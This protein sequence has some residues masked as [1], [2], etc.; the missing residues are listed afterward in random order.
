MPPLAQLDHVVINV[1]F[2]MDLADPLF[3]A[4]GFTLTPRAYDSQGSIHHLMVFGNNYLELSGLTGEAVNTRPELLNSP[5][6]IN[7]L[8]LK[9]S[10]VDQTYAHLQALGMAGDPPRTFSRTVYLSSGPATITLRLVTVRSDVFPAGQVYFCE[11]VT[12]ELVWRS[13][14]QTHANGAVRIAEIVIVSTDCEA[15][16]TRYAN[17]VAAPKLDGPDGIYHISLGEIELS[18]LS[19]THYAARYRDLVSPTNRRP[20][21][22]GAVVMASPD[23]MAITKQLRNMP[24]PAP[25]AISGNRISVRI[26]EFDSVLEFV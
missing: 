20:S 26:S 8:A 6:G 11:H 23:P 17:L 21:I 10:D 2:A 7:G 19:P 13:E 5:V 16:A 9:T 15:E 22:M 4:L 24:E 18:I 14:W 1:H 3:S 12:P 25:V